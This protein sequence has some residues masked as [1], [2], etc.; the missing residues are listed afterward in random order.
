[1][2]PETDTDRLIGATL[3]EAPKEGEALKING[4]CMIAHAATKEEVI[5]ELKRDVYTSGGVWD[6]EKVCSVFKL[7]ARMMKREEEERMC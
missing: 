4:S 5:E 6:W 7:W 2:C 3:D 1:M